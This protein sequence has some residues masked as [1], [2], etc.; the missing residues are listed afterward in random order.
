V[1]WYFE[2]SAGST[3]CFIFLLDV[4]KEKLE[5]HVGF[6]NVNQGELVFCV[7]NESRLLAPFSLGFCRAYCLKNSSFRARPSSLQQA[8]LGSHVSVKF[9]AQ[10]LHFLGALWVLEVGI[11]RLLDYWS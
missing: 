7:T 3:P 9:L 4:L 11:V 2:W 8:L 10:T 1:F 6:C 5:P